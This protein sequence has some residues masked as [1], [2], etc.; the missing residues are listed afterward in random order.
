MN[1]S[2][3]T[4]WFVCLFIAFL[5]FFFLYSVLKLWATHQDCG[6]V[7]AMSSFCIMVKCQDLRSGWRRRIQCKRRKQKIQ[8]DSRKGSRL[9][10]DRAEPDRGLKFMNHEIMTWTEIKSWTLNQLSHP[11]VPVLRIHLFCIRYYFR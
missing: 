4:E 10:A 11:G 2:P 7:R 8:N 9:C 1:E 6:W 5:S 3:L